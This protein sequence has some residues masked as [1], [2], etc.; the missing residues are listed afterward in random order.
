MDIAY[1]TGLVTETSPRRQGGPSPQALMSV[2]DKLPD[3]IGELA[4]R[5]TVDCVPDKE[6]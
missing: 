1:L 3:V 4:P 2:R 5:G 6:L